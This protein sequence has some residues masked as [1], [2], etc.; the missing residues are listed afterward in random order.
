[1]V[2]QIARKAWLWGLFV[3]LGV[4]VSILVL[5]PG[6]AQ[7]QA[8]S[9]HPATATMEIPPGGS[10]RIVLEVENTTDRDY[11]FH[12]SAA[13]PSHL[14]EGYRPIPDLSWI[15]FDKPDIELP[16]GSSQKVM[17]TVSIPDDAELAGEK[18]QAEVRFISAIE[19]TMVI[20]SDF[21]ITVGEASPAATGATNW[22]LLSG[23]AVVPIGGI[24]LW[25]QRGEKQ[26]TEWTTGLKE[27]DWFD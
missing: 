10:A 19:P 9:L 17:A 22:W 7:A 5:C 3:S 1:M 27:K 6:V 4:V 13:Q 11:T 24:I 26:R 8:I 16:R 25:H 18:Y 12:L 20:D 15:S 21:L 23:V 14:R 2:R